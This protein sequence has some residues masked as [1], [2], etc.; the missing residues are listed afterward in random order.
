METLEDCENILVQYLDIKL[1]HM[2]VKSKSDKNHQ[3]KTVV[4]FRL[5]LIQ[6]YIKS[7]N[8]AEYP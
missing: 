5:I 1:L 2:R 4:M 6:M 8:N 3:M 7:T